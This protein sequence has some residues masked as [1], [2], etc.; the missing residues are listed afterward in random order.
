MP[1]AAEK[2]Q[3]KLSQS[4]FV[5]LSLVISLAIAVA[6]ASSWTTS[7]TLR[8][9]RIE[10]AVTMGNAN[11]WTSIDMAAWVRDANREAE[12]WSLEMERNL[13]M[14]S[15]TWRRFRFPIPGESND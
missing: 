5:S 1:D 8:L 10:N 13:E 9:D 12:V 4:T 2:L 3:G 14:P 11:R 6:A 15:N 7:I